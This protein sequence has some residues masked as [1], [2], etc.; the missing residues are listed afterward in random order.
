[1]R[2]PGPSD[3]T[4]EEGGPPAAGG[5]SAPADRAAL[6][7]AE[8]WLAGAVERRLRVVLLATDP[9]YDERQVAFAAMSVEYGQAIGHVRALAALCGRLR[10]ENAVLRRAVVKSRAAEPARQP[11]DPAP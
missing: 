2:A 1:M 6:D 11:A 4:W 5:H 8:A 3:D 9:S 7:A 10:A